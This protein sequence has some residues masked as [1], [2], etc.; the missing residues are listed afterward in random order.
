MAIK[1]GDTAFRMELAVQA[2]LERSFRVFVERC[3]DWWPLEHRLGETDRIAVV[4][5]PR[6]GGRWYE[7]TK[8]GREN[9]WGR[10]LDWQPPDR[11]S[12]SWQIGLG[13]APED[14]QNSP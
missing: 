11:V 6:A 10:V 1:G 3:H 5:E 7:R 12:L 9:E 8:D 4:L 2:P 13:F 14:S